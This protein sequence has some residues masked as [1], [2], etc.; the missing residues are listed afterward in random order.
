MVAEDVFCILSRYNF[1]PIRVK[2]ALIYVEKALVLK[3]KK[4]IFKV[5]KKI[6]RRQDRGPKSEPESKEILSAP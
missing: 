6:I 3:S 2:H 1:N 4:V 5:S